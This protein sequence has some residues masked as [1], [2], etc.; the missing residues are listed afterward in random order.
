MDDLVEWLRQQIAETRTAATKAAQSVHEMHARPT[1]N[2]VVHDP[3][4]WASRWKYR[5]ADGSVCAGTAR[6]GLVAVAPWGGHLNHAGEHIALHDPVAVLAQCDAH[7][8]IL[9]ECV[10]V[11][12]VHFSD[13]F[14]ADHLAEAVIRQLGL[15]YQHRPGFREEWRS[16]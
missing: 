5:D 12:D 8:A 13:D 4:E 7:E 16:G 15:A 3:I 2:A 9:N 11:R 14:T 6:S 10:R 1:F